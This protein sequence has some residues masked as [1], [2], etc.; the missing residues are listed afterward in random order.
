MLLIHCP[1]CQMERPEIEFRYAGE[2]THRASSRS[3][4]GQ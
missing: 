4:K 2:A 3:L 1:Y